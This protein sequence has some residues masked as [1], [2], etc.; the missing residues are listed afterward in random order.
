M[1]KILIKSLTLLT[2]SVLGACAA[3][4]IGG[5][6]YLE[7]RTD[8]DRWHTV[9]L[10]EEF[11]A[12]SSLDS[13]A[14]YL[15]L[16]ERVFTQLDELIYTRIDPQAQRPSLRYQPDGV[17]NPA[18]WARN[19]NRSYE[20]PAENPRAGVLLLH[21][22]S[23]SPYSLHAVARSLHTAG[24]TVVGMR[25]PGHGT[26]PGELRDFTDE[27]LI[28]ATRLGVR[29][30]QSLIGDRPLYL[31]G[32]STGGA[33][34]ID[35]ALAG[36]DDDALPKI[37]GIVMISPAIGVMP[38]ARFAVWQA[39]IGRL[40]GLA[41]LEWNDITPEYDPFKYN[42]F[43][44]NAADVVYRLTSRISDHMERARESD[45]L[46][47]LPPIL[48]FQS[49]VDA[50]VSAPALIDGLL[51]RLPARGD[52]LVLF[53]IDRSDRVDSLLARNPSLDI[54]TAM[55]DGNL[56]FTVTLIT[57]EHPGTTDVI[58]RTQA[59]G[60]SVRSEMPLGM[61]WP[62]NVV[63][64]SHVALP[65]PASDPLYGA[66]PPQ[67]PNRLYLGN[68]SIRGEKGLLAVPAAAQLRLRWNP[69]FDYLESR[70]LEFMGLTGN[71]EG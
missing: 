30:V 57:N 22:I 17:A 1:R 65:F 13:Y 58:V 7:N 70:S 56:P 64:L 71:P 39:R 47:R 10:S 42:S 16:E 29:H 26:V 66:V 50:T 61:A 53:D 62:K 11:T 20:L 40:L 45:A 37:K 28:A 36:L 34:A 54:R 32:Y 15:K 27:D 44:I 55:S 38:A 69:F 60:S 67:E 4:L 25:L 19:W 49:I 35:Y 43:A 52:E 46:T 12:A 41:K 14:D 59:A 2:C 51:A 8:L 24:A 63:S 6:W 18:R 5:I 9:K 68:L 31:V 23:D 3:A 33:L 21:G 48:A